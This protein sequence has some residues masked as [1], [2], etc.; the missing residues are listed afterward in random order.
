M[1]NGL[2]DTGAADQGHFDMYVVSQ[3]GLTVYYWRTKETTMLSFGLD[4]SREKGCR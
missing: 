2:G 1:D 4:W 3:W